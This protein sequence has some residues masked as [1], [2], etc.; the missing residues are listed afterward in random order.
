MEQNKIKATSKKNKQGTE[1]TSEI[2]PVSPQTALSGTAESAGLSENMITENYQ[3]G[4]WQLQYVQCTQYVY[5][6]E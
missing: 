1:V 5:D 4:E 3:V 2:S 6:E